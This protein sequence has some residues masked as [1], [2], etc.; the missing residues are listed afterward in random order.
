MKKNEPKNHLQALINKAGGN[1]ELKL[2]NNEKILKIDLKPDNLR[3]WSETYERYNNPYNLLL[4]CESGSSDLN[5]TCLT[6]V[7]G[8]AIR[9]IT[10]K[11]K[12]KAIEILT[13][14]GLEMEVCRMIKENCPGFGEDLCW[15]IFLDRNGLTTASP[16]LTMSEINFLFIHF[17]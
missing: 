3:L 16:I 17:S 12:D 6:W 13:G 7:V 10:S 4:S 5:S 9:P 14:L 15:A 2:M 11:S 1:A 8:S